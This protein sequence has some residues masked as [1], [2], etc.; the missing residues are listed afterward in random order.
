LI[1][2]SQF[3]KGFLFIFNQNFCAMKN[4]Y[5]LLFCVIPFSL[6]SQNNEEADMKNLISAEAGR[7]SK[8]ED[9]NVNPNTLNYDLRYQ[10][11]E[12]NVDPDEIFISG[13]V[14]SHFIPHENISDIYFD[15][16]DALA[17]SEVQY[18][19]TNLTFTQLSSK[20]IKIDFPSALPENVIDSL[21]ISYSGVPDET[22]DGLYFRDTFDGKVAFSLT[23]PYGAR[24][25]F[26]TKQS[27]NDKIEKLDLKI[28]TPSQY[29][30]AGNG[31][32]ISETQLPGNKTLAF[33]QTN[34]PIPAYLVAIGVSNYVKTND[35]MGNP[36]FAFVNYIFPSSANNPAILNNIEWTKTVMNLFEEYYGPYPYRNEKYGH[37]EMTFG[38]GME[39]ATMTTLSG[40]S[41]SLI[42]HELTHQWFGDKITCGSWNDIWL[43]EGF[44]T[45][46]Q[47]LAREKLLNTNTEFLDFLAGE[48]DYITSVLGGSVHLPEGSEANPNRIFDGRLSYSKGG[49]VLRM[50]KWILGDDAFYQALKEYAQRP[51]LVYNYAETPDFNAS[52]LQ[53]TGKDFTGFFNDWIYGQGYPEYTIKWKQSGNHIAFEADQSQSY[54][55]VD[56]FEMTLPIKLN[57]TNGETQ[58]LRLENTYNGQ[59]FENPVN[60]TVSSVE[61]NYEYQILEKNSTV[62][63]DPTLSVLDQQK[64]IIKI[65]P[66]P[67]KDILYISGN[68]GKEDYEIVNTEGKLLM[69]GNLKTEISVARLQKGIYFLKTAGNITKF[70]KE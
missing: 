39:H 66:N 43:N 61:F 59:Y 56:F 32:L 25:W 41:K 23:E 11:L 33:W 30:T 3:V 4:L 49:Y 47:H 35:T 45:Y 22:Q 19:N 53:S 6:F 5:F 17:V 24:E 68:F 36:P 9:Y 14:T 58:Y 12:L 60:F 69:K 31:L 37:M 34:Y 70:I 67:V 18:H 57:G 48:K 46:G 54:S 20:E 13:K 63:L 40:F 44:A 15:F 16:T 50:L 65:Y 64:N 8:I 55:S 26:P 2:L 29:S 28:T 7:Y 52:L 62:V 21:S 27:M 1:S 38:G 51:D 10:R 42:A